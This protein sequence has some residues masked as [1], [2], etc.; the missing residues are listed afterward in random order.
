MQENSEKHKN[1]CPHELVQ[2][3]YCNKFVKRM[4]YDNHIKFKCLEYVVTCLNS[5]NGCPFEGPRRLVYKHRRNCEFRKMYCRYCETT[6]FENEYNEHKNECENHLEECSLCHVQIKRKN[7]EDHNRYHCP[8]AMIRCP[9]LLCSTE[10]PRCQMKKHRQEDCFDTKL[11]NGK[12][13]VMT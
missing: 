6:Y 2:C 8:Q 5:C 11:Q 9:G 10:V 12:V 4:S 1:E 3:T 13:L 7:L